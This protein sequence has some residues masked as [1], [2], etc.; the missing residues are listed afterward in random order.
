M[1]GY[2]SISRCFFNGIE[3]ELSSTHYVFKGL[4]KEKRLFYRFNGGLVT[5]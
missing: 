2:F 5:V 1:A 4:G 3:R